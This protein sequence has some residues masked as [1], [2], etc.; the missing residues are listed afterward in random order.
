[1][2]YYLFQCNKMTCL[3]VSL[4]AWFFFSIFFL[5]NILINV[6]SVLLLITSYYFPLMSDGC[7]AKNTFVPLVLS[8]T[9]SGSVSSY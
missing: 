1:M 9:G 2:V 4:S 3:A 7:V 6:P 8:S 5:I